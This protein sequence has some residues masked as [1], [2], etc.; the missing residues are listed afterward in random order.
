MPEL[1]RSEPLR[2]TALAI[3]VVGL[4]GSAAGCLAALDEQTRYEIASG[5]LSVF[6]VALVGS[7]AFSL[8]ALVWRRLHPGTLAS[9]LLQIGLLSVGMGLVGLMVLGASATRLRLS[10]NMSVQVGA[11]FIFVGGSIAPELAARL[12]ATVHPSVHLTHVV[13]SSGGG[14]VEGAVAAAD[15]LSARGVT[16]AV[17]EGD[18]SSAC[19]LLALM[20][21]ERI[22]TP[23]AAL[24]FH[25]LTGTPAVLSGARLVREDLIARLARNGISSQVMEGLLSGQVLQFPDRATLFSEKLITGCWA[26][27]SG[28]PVRCVD[29]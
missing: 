23:G 19:A 4:G 16:R 5:L 13:L 10:S 29:G 26:H 9:Q 2:A 17:I 11:D 1:A 12:K 8:G 18:C 15:W 24:G 28:T 6:A 14:S 3:V 7:V 27:R 20:F 21:P 25:D 22:L